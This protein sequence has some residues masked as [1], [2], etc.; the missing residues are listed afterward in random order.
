MPWE[1]RGTSGPYFYRHKREEDRVVKVYHGGGK[2]GE[3]AERRYKQYRAEVKHCSWFKREQAAQW[4]A[5]VSS[6]IEPAE[7]PE[8]VFTA[9]YKACGMHRPKSWVLR[10]KAG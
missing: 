6:V 10:R 1:M 7:A 4:R 9:A 3:R 2:R 8:S 5:F